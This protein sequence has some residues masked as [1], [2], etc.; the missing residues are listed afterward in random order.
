MKE[1][2]Y[3][4]F[5][6]ETHR[7]NWSLSK[8][9]IC[10]FELTFKCGLHCSHCYTDCYNKP[11][12]LKKELNTREVKLVLDK[13]YKSGVIWLCFTGGDPITRKDFLDI[14]SYAKNKGFIV[15]VFTSGIS[16][17]KE[18][19]DYFKKKPPF[20]IEMTLNASSRDLYEKISQ[21]KGSFD[22]A[23]RNIRLILKSGLPLKIKTQITKDSLKE[24]PKIKKFIEGLG[25]KF[26]PTFDLFSRLNGDLAPCNL[27]VS[28]VEVLSSNGKVQ[29]SDND[30]I[31]RNTNHEPRTTNLFPCSI[32]SGDGFQIDP[33]GRI[34]LCN[35]L[36]KPSLNLLKFDVK[37]A[38]N[39][40]LPLVRNSR[41]ATNSKCNGCN[42]RAD[43]RSCPG[44]ANLEMN[45][46]E[47]PIPYYCELAHLAN[48]RR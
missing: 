39:S 5:S 8:P 40:L 28:L 2:Q 46:L 44:K 43:C 22:K 47:A 6:W 3:K 42:L 21:V 27:R 32:S 25:L 1:A 36:R 38:L 35:L 14:Y 41:F 37:F 31:S 7:K 48:A 24:M 19:I 4:T 13:V 29:F 16:L 10:Q 17:T 11:D 23:M 33:Y 45:N 18:I 34:F 20:V 15:I 30:C 12:Y 26:H 9:S